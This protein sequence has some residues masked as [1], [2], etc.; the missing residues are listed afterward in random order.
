[1]AAVNGV[2]M[3]PGAGWRAPLPVVCL[4]KDFGGPLRLLFLHEVGPSLLEV[5]LLSEEQVLEKLV[6]L[7]S[8]QERP[9]K[10][11]HGTGLL[12]GGPILYVSYRL[13]TL[14]LLSVAELPTTL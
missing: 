10:R 1:A 12:S 6:L 9:W 3:L 2:R 8:N 5:L 11:P 4:L 7:E 13:S 14:R